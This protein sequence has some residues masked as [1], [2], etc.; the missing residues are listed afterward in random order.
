MAAAFN[1]IMGTEPAPRESAMRELSRS[2]VPLRRETK[3][4]DKAPDT[5]L[6]A[7]I[8]TTQTETRTNI[9]VKNNM[10]VPPNGLPSGLAAKPERATQR[11]NAVISEM[12][13]ESIV[14]ECYVPTGIFDI[15]LP[16]AVIPDELRTFGQPVTLSLRVGD[17]RRFPVVERREVTEREPLPKEDQIKKWIESI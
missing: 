15:R 8:G 14:L 12:Q 11:I 1:R 2:Q 17:G 9:D 4:P 10:V 5:N 7:P 16:P 3:L 13:S 6:L